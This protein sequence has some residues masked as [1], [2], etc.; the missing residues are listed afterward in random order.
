MIRR[1]PKTSTM[2]K[3]EL[4][5]IDSLENTIGQLRPVG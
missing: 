5:P 2:L 1:H 4:P 3:T